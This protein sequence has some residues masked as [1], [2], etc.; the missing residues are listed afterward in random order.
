MFGAP[1]DDQVMALGGLFQGA[2]LVSDLATSERF[3][4]DA[5]LA[6]ALSVIRI[7]A[8]SVDEVYGG[9][10][11]L[12]MGLSAIDEAFS[13]KLGQ[14]SRPVFAYSVAMHQLGMKLDG[15]SHMTD[16]I[17]QGLEEIGDM[18][19]FDD[20]AHEDDQQNL[21]YRELAGLYAK[22]IS[23][24]QPRIMVQ[25]SQGR[26]ENPVTVNRVRTALFAGI[27]SAYL[28]HQLGGRR[29]QLMLHRKTYQIRAREILRHARHPGALP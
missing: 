19:Q 2:Q 13:G 6:S 17:Q 12:A 23:T 29:W 8:D 7:D 4:D 25:G 20:I 14:R 18:V 10:D 15:F 3:S 24:M 22:T 27:R 11:S 5:L 16:V 1:Y 21:L 28:W 9:A 26:L